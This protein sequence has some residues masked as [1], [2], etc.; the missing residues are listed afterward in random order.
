MSR[1]VPF[2]EALSFTLM[3]YV[4]QRFSNSFS[5][6]FISWGDL[7][8]VKMLSMYTKVFGIF[9]QMASERLWATKTDATNPMGRHVKANCLPLMLTPK[10]F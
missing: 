1:L 5:R 6:E 8:E 9:L 7:A 4:L 2:P 10:Y 3:L